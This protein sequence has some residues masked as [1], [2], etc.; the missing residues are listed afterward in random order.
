META[1]D[2]RKLQRNAKSSKNGLSDE[3][4]LWEPAFQAVILRPAERTTSTRYSENR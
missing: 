3:S 1:G 2:P 4:E